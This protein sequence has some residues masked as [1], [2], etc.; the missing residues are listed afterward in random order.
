MRATGP[1]GTLRAGYQWAAD[2]G[3]WEI[4]A[5]SEPG[6]PAAFAFSSR[7]TRQHDYWIEQETLDLSL[8]IGSTEW[9]WRGITVSRD[10]TSVSVVLTERP[11]VSERLDD[12]GEEQGRRRHG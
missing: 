9:L 5:A 10:G 3:T 6:K 1:S 12:A 8:A 2:L 11:V 4:A 7:I